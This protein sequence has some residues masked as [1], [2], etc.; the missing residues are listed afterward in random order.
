MNPS[1]KQQPT[2]KMNIPAFIAAIALV[3]S[4][5]AWSIASADAPA[6]AAETHLYPSAE[7]TSADV[8]GNFKMTPEFMEQVNK[9]PPEFLAKFKNMTK[10]HT[11]F[12]H[13]ATARQV[14]TELV[15]D[16]NCVTTMLMTENSEGAADCALRASRHRW[17]KGHL[18]A[19]VQLNQINH[20][21]LSIL[22]TINGMVEVGL[23]Q[24]AELAMKKDFVA[25][26]EK[27]GGVLKG[28]AMCH[29]VFRFGK[30]ESPYIIEE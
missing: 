17:P 30:G 18:L 8:P 11:R 23:E 20:D 14:M 16:V 6:A 24:V 7:K 13:Q 19:Y 28:C 2:E 21:S 25:A 5:G 1:V 29:N 10:K 3:S 9:L 22:P 26:G 12:S 15:T 4:L 27:M